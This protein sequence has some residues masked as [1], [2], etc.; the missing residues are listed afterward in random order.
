MTD[1][2][3]LI[4]AGFSLLKLTDGSYHWKTRFSDAIS[5]YKLSWDDAE[6]NAFLTMK[7][8]GN[9]DWV[10]LPNIKTVDDVLTLARLLGLS[11]EVE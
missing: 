6:K 3:K 2:Q 11:K 4:A 10:A 5:G 7:I 1:E 9:I 8:G